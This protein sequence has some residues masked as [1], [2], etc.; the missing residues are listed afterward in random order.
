MLGQIAIREYC[1]FCKTL[2][3]Y[4]VSK[5]EAV[6]TVEGIK[7]SYEAKHATCVSC[8]KEIPIPEF[9]AAN[10]Q[11]KQAALKGKKTAVAAQA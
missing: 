6:T 3:P 5:E 7:V 2:R 1:P 9:D 8:L 10:E 4:S 11:S